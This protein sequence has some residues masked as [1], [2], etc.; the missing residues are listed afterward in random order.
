MVNPLPFVGTAR[1][2][3]E[4]AG[5]R[6]RHPDDG[7]TRGASAE[8]WHSCANL[9]VTKRTVIKSITLEHACEAFPVQRKTGCT[10]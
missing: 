4:P 7:L 5:V 1:I 10:H 3:V 9:W 8:S 2:F 6:N